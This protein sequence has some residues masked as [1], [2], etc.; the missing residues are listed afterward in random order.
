MVR[1]KCTIGDCFLKLTLFS[2]KIVHLGRNMLETRFQ[3]LRII[4]IAHCVGK[5]EHTD[6]KKM[7]GT[8]D[9]IVLYPVCCLRT[10]EA[11][12]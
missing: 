12:N 9:F 11:V 4:N 6:L 10:G 8:D 5:T 2:L 7:Y 3:Y 1:Y